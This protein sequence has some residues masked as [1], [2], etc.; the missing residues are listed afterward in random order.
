M[1]ILS[2]IKTVPLSYFVY[3]AFS[4]FGRRHDW[5]LP[6]MWF[7]L[8]MAEL[9]RE[10]SAVRQTLY[11][12]EQDGELATQKVGRIKRYSPSKFAASEIHVG[13]AKIFAPHT[14]QWDGAWTMV[15]LS[16]NA[17]AQRVARERIVALLAVEGF[18]LLGADTYIH[19][20]SRAEGLREALSERSRAHVVMLRGPLL[21]PVST[22]RLAELWNVQA[23]ATR[24]RRTYTRLKE[25][26]SSLANRELSDRDHFVLRYA[27]VFDYLG[28]AWDDPGLPAAVL[29]PEWPAENA[30]TLAAALYERLLPGATR[31][32]EQL[33]ERCSPGTAHV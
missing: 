3:S 2:T 15:H 14:R 19:P 7:V 6:G 5:Q 11:R 25:V 10:A 33:L 4:A 27:V 9:G 8:S 17:P 31:Y 32:A 24:Y 22:A 26:E 28:V 20:H 18:A 12:M 30:R 23:L 13:T 1:K 29:P 21:E 16:L